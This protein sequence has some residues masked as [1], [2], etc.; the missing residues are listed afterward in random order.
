MAFFPECHCPLF[1]SEQMHWVP[2]S[3]SYYSCLL[4][5]F[6]IYNIKAV[7]QPLIRKNPHLS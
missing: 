6:V 5:D 3:V 4:A 1:F 7:G 2:I